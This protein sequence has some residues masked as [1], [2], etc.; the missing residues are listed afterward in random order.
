MKQTKSKIIII[1]L[2]LF[3]PFVL[4]L[5]LLIIPSIFDENHRVSLWI[6]NGIWL[7]K[8]LEIKDIY[9]Y[10]FRAGEDF[11]IWIY[12]E[13]NFNK[14]ISKSYFKRITEDNIERLK[15]KLTEYYHRLDDDETKLFDENVNL[16]NLP[17]I[18][19]HFLFKSSKQDEKTFILI[20]TD[21]ATN[22]LYFFNAVC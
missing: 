1:F 18:G 19:N 7:P 13:E 14:G 17:L 11:S 10:E 2:V 4:Y 16:K 8:P 6:N 15:D 21:S 3:L 22:S 12:D 20:I 9:H 5:F